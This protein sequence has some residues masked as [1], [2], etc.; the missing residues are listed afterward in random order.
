MNKQKSLI[1]K[2][3]SKT[4]NLLVKSSIK[5]AVDSAS[6]LNLYQP[7]APKNLK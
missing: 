3:Y 1:K 7:K 6:I 4:A 2:I 5:I